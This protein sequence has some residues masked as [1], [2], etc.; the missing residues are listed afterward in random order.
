MRNLLLF[1]FTISTLSVFSQRLEVNPNVQ[2]KFVKSQEINFQSGRTYQFE[3]PA[4]KGYDYI[5]NLTHNLPS[6]FTSISVFDMQYG[7]VAGIA[8]S[9]NLETMDLHFRV[10]QNGTYIVVLG[11]KEGETDVVIP[12]KVS[13]VRR[14]IVEY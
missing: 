2:W 13:L 3:F 8:D 12:S 10:K 14:P 9:S 4:E 6:A 1:I 5:F 7:P 11:L